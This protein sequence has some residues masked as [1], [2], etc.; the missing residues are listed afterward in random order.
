VRAVK[1]ALKRLIRYLATR[2]SVVRL[3]GN[4][5][6]P[7]VIQY[8]RDEIRPDVA[9]ASGTVEALA[10][11]VHSYIVLNEELRPQGEDCAPDGL[12]CNRETRARILD[13]V[14]RHAVA[15]KG[16]VFEF[17]VHEGESLVV[18]AERLPDRHVHG[19][20][21]FEGL[22]EEWWTRPKGTFKTE[23]PRINRPNVTLVKGY[24]DESVPRFLAAWPGDVSLI[25]VD[26]VLYQSTRDCLVPMLSRCQVGTVLLF[27]EYY[28]YPEFARHE[29]LAWREIRTRH[30]ILAPCVAYDGRRAAFKIL[31]LGDLSGSGNK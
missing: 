19:F 15:T 24:F 12:P 26:C 25:H 10:W 21:S 5:I 14:L 18:F 27:D 28:N 4:V 11:K 3:V 29:W 20:D 16:D 2:E 9:S 22:P 31:D 8:L 30:N 7:G 1:K 13:V 17:G 23:P 6:Y